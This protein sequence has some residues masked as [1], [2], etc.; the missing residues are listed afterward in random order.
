MTNAKF[1][2]SASKEKALRDKMKRFGIK[3]SDLIENFIRAGKKGGQKL[4]KTST[5]V[6]LKHKPTGIEVKC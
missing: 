4:N 5:C 1:G 3:E 2:V 6:Y